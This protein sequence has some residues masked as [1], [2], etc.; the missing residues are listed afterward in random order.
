MKRELKGVAMFCDGLN[1]LRDF[2]HAEAVER[3]FYD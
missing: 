2:C 3:G 1:E